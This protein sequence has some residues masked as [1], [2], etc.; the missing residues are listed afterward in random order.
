MC[1]YSSVHFQM[2]FKCI[3]VKVSYNTKAGI[4]FMITFYFLTTMLQ[5][6]RNLYLLNAVVN[7]N[8]RF[9]LNRSKTTASR[10]ESCQQF[11]KVECLPTKIYNYQNQSE[12]Q[13]ISRNRLRDR[14]YDN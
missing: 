14:C 9:L 10:K 3:S 4:Y 11:R 1:Y 5:W 2:F 6:N 8:E 13:K 7:I 12:G